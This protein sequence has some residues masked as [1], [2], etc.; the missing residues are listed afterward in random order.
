MLTKISLGQLLMAGE[1]TTRTALMSSGIWVNSH[2]SLQRIIK[3]EI[4]QPINSITLTSWLNIIKDNGYNISHH[5][6]TCLLSGVLYISCP[7]GSGDIVFKD[8]RPGSFFGKTP[9][10]PQLGCNMTSIKVTP[11]EGLLCSFLGT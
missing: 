3:K 10:S 5:H 9:D 2:P 6:G 11:T 4:K 1:L 7:D 8:P